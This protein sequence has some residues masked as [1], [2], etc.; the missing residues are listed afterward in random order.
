MNRSLDSGLKNDGEHFTFHNIISDTSSG[1]I[2]QIEAKVMQ[3]QFLDSLSAAEQKL[4]A[5]MKNGCYVEQIAMELSIDEDA[6][7]CLGRQ[8]GEKRKAFYAA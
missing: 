2:S 3:Q 4:Y 7:I 1:R 5:M 6:M 8:I